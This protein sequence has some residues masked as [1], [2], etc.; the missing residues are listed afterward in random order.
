M[1][2]FKKINYLDENGVTIKARDWVTVGT[3]GVLDGVTYTAV[4]NSTLKSMADNDE[5]VTKVVTTLVTSMSR[6]F[7][8]KERLKEI[9]AENK[10]FKIQSL[11]AQKVH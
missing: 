7:V 3:K 9:C 1:T 4:D 11:C 2:K 10:K 6:L 8:F 5:D